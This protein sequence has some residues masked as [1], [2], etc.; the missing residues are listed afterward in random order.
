MQPH[1]YRTVVGRRRPPPSLVDRRSAL[2]LSSAPPAYEERGRGRHRNRFPEKYCLYVSKVTFC[3][4][5]TFGRG[6]EDRFFSPSECVR[7]IV[8]MDGR[9]FKLIFL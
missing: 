3:G 7:E 8:L 9:M 1:D 5:H 4:E 6:A 2:G